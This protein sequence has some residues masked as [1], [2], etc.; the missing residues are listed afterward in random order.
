MSGFEGLLVLTLE[1]IGSNQEVD[2]MAVVA[3]TIQLVR[4]HVAALVHSGGLKGLGGFLPLS[5]LRPD[6][7]G[8]VERVR[9]VGHQFRVAAAA[10]PGVFGKGRALESVDYI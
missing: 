10:G 3:F 9:N 5:S 8:H 1:T 7:A 6:M 4:F 2:V